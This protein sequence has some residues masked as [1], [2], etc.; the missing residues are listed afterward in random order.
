MSTDE[1][2]IQR[3]CMAQLRASHLCADSDEDGE[4]LNVDEGG[5]GMAQG[6]SAASNRAAA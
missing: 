6:T 3:Q 5:E 1:A 2:P 4:G